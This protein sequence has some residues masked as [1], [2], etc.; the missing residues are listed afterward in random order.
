MS[1][2]ICAIGIG[3]TVICH[4]ALIVLTCEGKM[5]AFEEGRAN[6]DGTAGFDVIRANSVTKLSASNVD[7]D[8]SVAALMGDDIFAE[9]METVTAL[10]ESM[11]KVLH[12][13]DG[14]DEC[15]DNTSASLTSTPTIESDKIHQTE[16]FFDRGCRY[17]QLSNNWCDLTTVDFAKRRHSKV[18]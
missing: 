5:R 16:S 6:Y 10:S 11:L 9:P 7:P 13:E 4:F 3:I 14:D 12:A 17:S 2:A 18:L 8:Q 1:L 15:Q